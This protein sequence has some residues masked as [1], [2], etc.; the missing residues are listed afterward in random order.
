M[1]TTWPK[2]SG[3]LLILSLGF[4]LDT[5][6]WPQDSLQILRSKS[7]QGTQEMPWPQGSHWVIRISPHRIRIA[8]QGSQEVSWKM[9]RE[10]RSFKLSLFYQATIFHLVLIFFKKVVLFCRRPE[11][12]TNQTYSSCFYFRISWILMERRWFYF[13]R[14]LHLL[15]GLRSNNI[16]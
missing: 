5:W 13:F 2:V 3:I 7:S 10:N 12:S 8:L 4:G 14:P 6:I 11:G 15:Q 16:K 9:A 1:I